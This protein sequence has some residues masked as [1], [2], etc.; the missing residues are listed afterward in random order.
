MT[1]FLRD[2][3]YTLR[4]FVKNPGVTAIMVFSLALAIGANTAIFSVVYG[5]L[6]RPL[7]YPKPDQLVTVYEVSS[8]GRPMHFADPNLEDA[9]S[10]NHTLQGLAEYNGEVE[11]VSGAIEPS[12]TFV[13][14][15]SKD[16]LSVIGVHPV[17]G[18]EFS[19]NEQKVGGAPAV[20]VSDNYWRQDLGATA[21]LSQFKLK[22]GNHAFSVIGVLPPGFQFP[23][24]SDIWYPRELF[25]LNS[26]RTSHNGPV[27][28]RMRDGVSLAQ[29]RADL[30]AI[31]KE[32]VRLHGTEGSSDFILHGIGVDALQDTMTRNVRPALILLLGAVGFLLLVAC[33]NV[34]NLLLSQA[35]ARGR[36]LAVRVALG[37]ARGRLV[38]Q[39]LAE[40]L[41]LSL[42]GG[43]F[44]VF[45]AVWGVEGLL[46]VAPKDIPRLE[47]VAVNLPVLLFALGVCIAV[48]VSLGVFTALRATSGD[49][50]GALVEGGRGQAG[51][52]GSQRIGRAIVAAQV[53][54]T[55]ALLVGAGLLGRSLYSVLSVDPGFRTES[56]L[57]MSLNMPWAED[58]AAK[59]RQSEQFSDIFTRLRGI[60]GVHEVGAAN[61][62]P[63]DGG[64]ANGL[65]F[66]ARGQELPKDSKELEKFWKDTSRTGDADYCAATDGYFRALS[67]RLVR[68]RLFDAHDGINAPH[69]AVINESLARLKWPAKDPIGRTIEFGNMDGDLRLLTIVGIVGDVHGDSL[70]SRVRPTVYVN[71]LQRPRGT[72]TIVMRADSDPASVFSVARGIL[73][74]VAPDVPPRFRTLAQV[75]SA[76]IGS[77]QF[78]V[79]LVGAFAVT[80]LL[81]ALA[82]I[83]GV[84]SYTVTRRTREIGVRMALGAQSRDVL[85]LVLRQG[86]VT[87]LIGVAIG[88]VGAF[89]LT[90]TMQS[91]LFGVEPTDPITFI[92]VA[93]MLTF[94]AIV[95]SYLPARRATRVDPIVALRYE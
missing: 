10:M 87:A 11:S 78:N 58:A 68:G 22:I 38:L 47:S 30:V 93:A 6:L 60:P 82:G 19:P 45:A 61:E 4:M 81:L 7:P 5:V 41:I 69:V 54:I 91:L 42:L 73:H 18:R 1:N 17:I 64:L 27:I 86:M 88:L 33:A 63:L 29:A 59:V 2:I 36:E 28:G 90:R 32:L 53:A 15:V 77:R 16:F 46:A 49:F 13:T 14:A 70:E 66:D 95:A 83:Y 39:F 12:R 71:L 52:V 34:A 94:V 76:S 31:G 44:G 9:R 75:Y 79:M 37:A 74:D 24:T 23:Q 8:K 84:M 51:S 50:R 56:V 43:L 35:S 57:A 40:A 26:S 89:A 21:D 55:L 80:A 62:I 20:L 3:R 72:L 48:A 25:G 92:G 67:I 85:A 65:F